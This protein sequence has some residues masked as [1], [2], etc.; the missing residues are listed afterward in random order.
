MKSGWNW[1]TDWDWEVMRRAVNQVGVVVMAAGV[2]GMFLDNRDLLASVIL[3][4]IAVLLLGLSC[5]RRYKMEPIVVVA[6]AAALPLIFLLF[7]GMYH[8]K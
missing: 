5:M 6:I 8:N 7:V 3:L 1:N 2:V 4:S